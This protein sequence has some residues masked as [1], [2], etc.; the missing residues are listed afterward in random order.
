MIRTLD[1]VAPLSEKTAEQLTTDGW[2]EIYSYR[3]SEN[4]GAINVSDIRLVLEEIDR[5]MP[6]TLRETDWEVC[7]AKLEATKNLNQVEQ[8]RLRAILRKKTVERENWEHY[9]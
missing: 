6:A 8:E 4:S 2:E 5:L 1:K 3:E 9:H 7:R